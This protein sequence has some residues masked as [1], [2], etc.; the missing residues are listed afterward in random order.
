MNGLLLLVVLTYSVY[1]PNLLYLWWENGNLWIHFTKQFLS[2]R[3]MP[4]WWIHSCFEEKWRNRVPK[5]MKCFLASVFCCDMYAFTHHVVRF[6]SVL[7][8]SSVFLLNSHYFNYSSD[9]SF[10]FWEIVVLSPL[11]PCLLE[12]SVIWVISIKKPLLKPRSDCSPANEAKHKRRWG[13]EQ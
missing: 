13:Q 2:L 7:Q 3:S 12:K 9:F 5:I 8:M 6:L 11:T 1:K 10:L 4:L